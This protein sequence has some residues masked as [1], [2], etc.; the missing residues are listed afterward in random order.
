MTE[1]AWTTIESRLGLDNAEA[2]VRR[3]ITPLLETV[4][5]D[6]LKKDGR[7]ESR[8]EPAYGVAFFLTVGGFWSVNAIL[9][10]DFIGNAARFILLPV[11]FLLSFAASAFIFRDRVIAALTKGQTR[12]II[13]SKA[14]DRL[15]QKL[16]LTYIPAPGG[17]SAALKWLAKQ[18]WA[19]DEMRDAVRTLEDR[20]G[21]DKAVAITRRSGVMAPGA[22]V[23][24]SSKTKKKY[25]AQYA[26][27]VQA[28]DG[29][30]GARDG[31][32]FEAFEWLES[33]SDA[34]DI[35]HLVI[36]FTTPWRLFGVTQLRTRAIAWPESAADLNFYPV[37]VIAPAF[38]DR[39]RLR[40][41]DQVEARAIFDPVVLERVAGLARGEKARA[42]A[43]TN[44]LV[45]DV[46]GADRFAMVDLLTGEWSEESVKRT[47]INI[48]EMIELADAVARAF[49]L[50]A[51][52]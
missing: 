46:E 20:G 48:A 47:M 38:E 14:L 22:P 33:K 29:F 24:A 11:L 32:G 26:E 31:V 9:P 8:L 40:A 42:A 17:A 21:M 4:P 39:F 15:A 3:E 7:R 34:S 30:Q 45:V 52:A 18:N 6:R 25:L 10:H 50:H 41:T 51:A 43:F 13:R 16:G 5:V 36:V 27:N 37:G 2:F 49:K 12:F 44:H 19:P 35:H 23:V 1:P 28:E